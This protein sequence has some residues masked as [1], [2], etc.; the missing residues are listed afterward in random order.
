M[1]KARGR[2]TQLR[3]VMNSKFPDDGICEVLHK[4]AVVAS[5]SGTNE[6]GIVGV[7][8]VTDR[9]LMWR[10]AAYGNEIQILEV[11]IKP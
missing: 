3:L 4:G 11:R 2:P 5:I 1:S 10:E 9:K 6:D 8:I 7:R